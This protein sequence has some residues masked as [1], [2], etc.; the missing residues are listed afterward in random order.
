MRQ[1]RDKGSALGLGEALHGVREMDVSAAAFQQVD[2][3]GTQF[4]IVTVRSGCLLARRFGFFLHRL[5]YFSEIR[6]CCGTS[7]M[8]RKVVF[9]NPALPSIFSYCAKV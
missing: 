4:A 5:G 8:G 2:E 3:V 1:S 9:A 7:G 6:T